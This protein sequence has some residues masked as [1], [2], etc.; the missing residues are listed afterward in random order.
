MTNLVSAMQG[1]EKN[2]NEL[3]L[4]Q[5]SLERIVQTKFHDLDN[6]VEQLT[7][8]VNQLKMWDLLCLNRLLLL[9]CLLEHL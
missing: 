3:L 7:T 8:T 6:K 2:I 5:K 4:N 9:Q 1:M